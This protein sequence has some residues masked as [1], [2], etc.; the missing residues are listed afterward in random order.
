MDQAGGVLPG[1][2]AGPQTHV[3]GVQGQI[4]AE[5][6]A[7]TVGLHAASAFNTGKHMAG[8]GHLLTGEC[9]AV[10]L[11]G[12]QRRSR[13]FAVDASAWRGPWL[14]PRTS[15]DA[16]ALVALSLQGIGCGVGRRR[17]R[18]RLGAGE[19]LLHGA[20]DPL[21]GGPDG[22]IGSQLPA[23]LAGPAVT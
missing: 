16:D 3:E 11:P 2:A 19:D 1:S 23:S 12:G 9:D 20:D 22:L 8:G 7:G 17:R 18:S 14:L 5:A 10:V 13:T 4:G 6:G 21:A 15:R